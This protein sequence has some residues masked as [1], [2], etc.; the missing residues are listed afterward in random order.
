MKKVIIFLLVISLLPIY[1]FDIN[2]K[3]ETNLIPNAT[4][5][6]LLEVST[7]KIIYEKNINEEVS[8]AS[9]TKMMGLILIF[10][11]IKNGEIKYNDKVTA[12]QNASDMGGSQI[13]LSAGEIMTVEDLLKGI[14]M[15]SA[16]DGIVAMAEYVGGTEANFVK[17]MNDKAKELGLEHTNFV[18]PTGLD[19][20]GHYSSAYDVAMIALELMKYPDVFKFTTVYEGYLRDNTDNKFW[21]VNTNKLIATYNGADGLKTGMTDNAGYCMAVT[22]K[23]NGMRLLAVVLG[24][25]QG[26]VRNSETASLLD[27]GFNLYEVDTIKNKGDKVG[28]ISLDKA[29]PNKIDVIVNEDVTILKRKGEETKEYKSE[30]KLKDINLPVKQGEV[31]GELLIK[32]NNQVI[33]KVDLVSNNDMTKKSFINLYLNILKSILTGTMIS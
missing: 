9:L 20:E 11:K 25:K 32:D 5:G 7:G 13:W 28:E 1:F 27:Y 26:K 14:I 21:L 2:V 17:M 29:N 24:E 15:A 19:E 18:N 16:N 31:I 12:S 22:A 8:I 33:K 6:I 30:V 23:R 10:E 3:A 4:N